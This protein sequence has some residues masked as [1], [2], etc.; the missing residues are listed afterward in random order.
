MNKKIYLSLIL[1]FLL[2]CGGSSYTTNTQ[3]PQQPQQPQGVQYKT[4][5]EDITL[6]N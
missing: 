6:F 4:V 1:L 5:P 2:S 3:Q